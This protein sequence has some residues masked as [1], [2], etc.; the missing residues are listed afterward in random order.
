MT[1]SINA[2]VQGNSATAQPLRI[3]RI[4]IATITILA[5]KEVRDSLRNRWFILYT[6]A[7]TALALA[8]AFLSLAGTGMDGLAGFGRTAA[9][10]INLVIL[11]VPLMALTAGAS[12]LASERERGTLS[13]LLAQ[14]ISKLELLL[15]KYLGLAIALTASLTLGFGLSAAIMALRGGSTD[16][17]SFLWLLS[18]SL[19]LALGML[20]VGFLISA[21]TRKASV[22]MGAAIFLWLALEFLGDLGLMGSAIVLKL[23]VS[24]LFYLSLLNPMQVFKMAALISIH[25]SLD[26]LGPAGIFATQNFGP[27]LNAIFT[28]VLAAWIIIPLTLAQLLFAKRGAV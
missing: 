1:A 4:S 27:A 14:P 9:S 7:F 15:G 13:Y 18:I 10:L 8:L 22:A 20:S 23:Q 3:P 11:I 24:E 26:V 12:S 17:T 21:I 6:L 16:I 2:P 28:A 25:A 5:R 19:V